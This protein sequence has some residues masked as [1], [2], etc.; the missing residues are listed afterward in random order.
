MRQ[1][2]PLH[3]IIADRKRIEKEATQKKVV[4]PTAKKTFKKKP[5]D[6]LQGKFRHF[7][8]DLEVDDDG[9]KV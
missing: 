3:Q 9:K 2:K 8:G 6:M 5:I 4:S 1:P 7:T